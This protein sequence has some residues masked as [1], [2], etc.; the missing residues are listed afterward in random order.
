MGWQ[1]P[2]LPMTPHEVAQ[3]YGVSDE[4]ICRE[5]RAGRLK[6]R[7]KRGGVRNWYITREALEEW[8]ESGFLAD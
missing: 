5:I 6:A 4:Y 7:H 3:I 8:A 1:A 2:P